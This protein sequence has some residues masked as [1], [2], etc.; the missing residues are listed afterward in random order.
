VALMVVAT[1]RR[2]FHL[3]VSRPLLLL[4][5]LQEEEGCG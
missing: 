5:L 4:L 2:E 1:A 3:H